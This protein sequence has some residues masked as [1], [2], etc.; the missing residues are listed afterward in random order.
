[1]ST[2]STM[3]DYDYKKIAE[4]IFSAKPCD[5]CSSQILPVNLDIN[6]SICDKNTFVFEMLINIYL[7]GMMMIINRAKAIMIQNNI[8]NNIES[9][10]NNDNRITKLSLF[11]KLDLDDFM[12]HDKWFLGLGYMLLIE[13]E[14]ICDYKDF[15]NDHYCKI[16]FKFVPS[17][18]YFFKMKNISNNFHFLLNGDYT[19]KME[20]NKIKAVLFKGDYAYVIRFKEINTATVCK[21]NNLQMY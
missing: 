7:E 21:Q 6:A 20:L 12:F 11:R 19:E 1:M 9:S 16:L 3:T 5:L 18:L 2:I 15:Q 13:K 4:H 14:L 10:K 17:D 8:Q